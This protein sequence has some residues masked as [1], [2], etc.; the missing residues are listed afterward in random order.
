M[1]HYQRVIFLVDLD[2]LLSC[3]EWFQSVVE[4]LLDGAVALL[5]F[6]N[7]L[8]GEYSARVGIN[9]EVRTVPC[10]EQH[11]VGSLFAYSPNL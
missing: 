8:M 2:A 4:F 6:N 3:V 11:A 10:I 5:H 9:N 7:S 1:L